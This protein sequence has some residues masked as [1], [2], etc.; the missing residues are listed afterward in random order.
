MRTKVTQVYP[1]ILTCL[2]AG[3]IGC[4]EE[5][6]SCNI[7]TGGI[8]VEYTVNENNAEAVAQAVFWVGDEPGGT[9]LE[10]GVCGDRVEVNGHRLTEYEDRPTRYAAFIP[11]AEKYEFT[12]IRPD[13]PPHVSVA[14]Q[15]PEPV[16]FIAPD[17]IDAPRDQPLEIRW[18]NNWSGAATLEIN[19]SCIYRH[20]ETVTDNGEH[21]LAANR[22]AAKNEVITPDCVAGITLARYFHGRISPNLKGSVSGMVLSSTYCNSTSSIDGPPTSFGAIDDTDTGNGTME[23]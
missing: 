11:V 13:E 23:Q 18:E 8:Y 7:K 19:G 12:F 21:T 14:E 3:L 17:G 16:H 6:D 2:M 20:V 4:Y 10:L 5:E 9:N 1:F 15:I 22:L